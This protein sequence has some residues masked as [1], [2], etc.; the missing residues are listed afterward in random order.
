MAAD[1]RAGS[2]G[3]ARLESPWAELRNSSSIVSKSK[4]G[5]GGGAIFAGGRGA[6][7][8]PAAFVPLRWAFLRGAGLQV[9]CQVSAATSCS[10]QLSCQLLQ[11]NS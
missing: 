9:R 4:E 3:R 11:P 6:E 1:L 8:R 7:E 5:R 2:A 10:D